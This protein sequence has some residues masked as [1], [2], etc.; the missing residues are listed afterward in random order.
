MGRLGLGLKPSSIWVAAKNRNSVK[1][2]FRPASDSQAAARLPSRVPARMPGAMR[3]TVGQSTAP[4][5]WW[6]RRLDTEV[7]TMTAME[8]PR[9]RWILKAGAKPWAA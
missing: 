7:S 8:V 9:A 3:R 5:P 1:K 6:A 4:W 2:T